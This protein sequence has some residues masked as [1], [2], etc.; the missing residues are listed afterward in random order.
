MITVTPQAAKQI[1]KSSGEEDGTKVFLRLA[2]QRDPD[3]KLEYGMGF[4]EPKDDDHR[5][6]SEGINVLISPQY[7]ALLGG[8]TIDFVEI[9]PGDYR[10]IFQNPN[11]D[12]HRRTDAGGAAQES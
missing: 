12:N 7:V 9:N 10:F 11:D 1:L 4:D 3:G 8:S 5:V 6:T 2:A